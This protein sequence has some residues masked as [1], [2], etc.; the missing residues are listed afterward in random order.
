V[1]VLFADVKGSMELAEQVDP[2]A[3]H[4]ILDRF[5]QILADGVHRF[6]G[7]VN[8]YTGDGFMALFGAPIAHEDHAQRACYASLHLLEGLRSYAR[9]VKRNHGLDFA[10]RIGLHSG[11]VVVGKIGDDLRMDYTAQGHIVGLAQRMES[12]AEPN[13]CFVS[14]ATAALAHGY[15]ALDDL[16]PFRVKG[17][18]DLLGTDSSTAGLADAIHARTGGNPFFAEE[19]VRS[20]IESGALQGGRGAYRLVT[21]V[22]RLE[23][24]STVQPVLAARIDRLPER[25]KRVLQTA[26]VIGKEFSE[27]VLARVA[28]L[29]DDELG[30]ALRAFAQMG[31]AFRVA[32]IRGLLDD[33]AR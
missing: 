3:W 18:A 2:E 30:A 22:D 10:A 13:T 32:H 23:V 27:P 15:V 25:E 24:P 1:T 6:E 8:Q 21:S 11:D 29:P 31:A 14:G 9:E 7:T 16:G 28:D 19:V 26:A 33:S 4:Q 5:F 20:L 12:L 17:V